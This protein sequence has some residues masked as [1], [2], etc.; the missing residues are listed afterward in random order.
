VEEY[1][2]RRRGTRRP[3]EERRSMATTPQPQTITPYLLYEDADAAAGWLTEAFGAREVDRM[4]GGAGGLHV[5][6]ELGDGGRVYLGT[7]PGDFHGPRRVGRTSLLYVL[8]GDVD[9]HFARAC[10]ADAE[11]VEEPADQPY[12]HRRYTCRDPEGHEWTFACP[13]NGGGETP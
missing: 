8:V 3:T 12:G 6:L 10:E 2:L 9:A 1:A 11:V 4:H 13:L 7:P 5:E